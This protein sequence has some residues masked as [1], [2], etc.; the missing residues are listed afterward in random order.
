MENI[1]IK[2]RWN[3]NFIKEE[4][5]KVDGSSDIKEEIIDICN[6]F[7]GVI[8][9]CFE[10]GADK[11]K[12]REIMKPLLLDFDKI[13]ERTEGDTENKALYML[14]I[15]H[16]ADIHFLL[17]SEEKQKEIISQKNEKR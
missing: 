2:I 7:V 5:E 13:I 6:A 14:L 4:A 16:V 15:T 17:A 1:L 9:K 12:A 10:V 11:E 3:I 8:S